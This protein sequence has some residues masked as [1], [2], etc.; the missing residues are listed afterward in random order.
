M[1]PTCTLIYFPPYLTQSR[2][3]KP[4]ELQYV[5]QTHLLRR[6]DDS[7]IYLGVP[8]SI[9]GR[10]SSNYFDVIEDPL[11]NSVWKLISCVSDR[12]DC[13]RTREPELS[14]SAPVKS[15]SSAGGESGFAAGAV[16]AL[17]T[18]PAELPLNP[19]YTFDTFVVGSCNQ[20]AHAALSA[21]VDMPS[22][23]YKPLYVYGGVG[24]GK[25]H[26]MHAIGH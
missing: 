14:S 8:T 24:L 13:A 5:V 18:E 22:K 2:N 19:K 15:K 25:T 26:L 20:F 23:T 4:A 6:R 9:S 3:G 16:R 21:V 10:I 12:G 7:S 1:A 17:E 11:T